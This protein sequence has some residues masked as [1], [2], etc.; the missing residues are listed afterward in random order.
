MGNFLK[1]EDIFVLHEQNM[2]KYKKS[3]VF[4]RGK[5]LQV[6]VVYSVSSV[7][8]C[9]KCYYNKIGVITKINKTTVNIY[10]KDDTLCRVAIKDLKCIIGTKGLDLGCW[11]AERHK[12]E[13]V[14]L[15]T[16]A[17][18]NN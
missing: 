10:F 8:R 6:G 14:K 11:G 4:V 16:K 1:Q 17:F 2:E 3:A 5:P 18:K 13:V 15:I 12:N 9:G 7:E